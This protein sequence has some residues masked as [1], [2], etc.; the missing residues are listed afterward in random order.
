MV[1]NREH[2]FRWLPGAADPLVAF[3][4]VRSETPP[5]GLSIKNVQGHA[6]D[7]YAANLARK[8]G[9]D[10]PQRWRSTTLARLRSWGFNTIGNWSDPKLY[11]EDLLPYTATLQIR[12]AGADIPGSEDYW[13]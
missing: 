7:F 6:F 1:E 13:S 12:G 10:W 4:S 5:L 11:K 9:V 2:M 3:Y 8:Y